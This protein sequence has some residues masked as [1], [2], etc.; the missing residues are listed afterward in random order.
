MSETETDPTPIPVAPSPEPRQ[1][2]AKVSRSTWFLVG[3]IL[4]LAVGL[5]GVLLYLRNQPQPERGI[6]P[7][8]EIMAMDPNSE[9]WG[10]NFPNQL[11][12]LKQTTLNNTPTTY[13]GSDPYSHLERDPR[14]VILFAGYPFSID[15]NEE[16][17]HLYALED[18]RATK[19]VNETTAGTCY[20]CKSSNN[21]E[22]WSKMGMAAYDKTLF[23]ELGKQITQPIGCA[24]CHEANTMRLVVTNPALEEG[25]KA[26]GLD[27][28][29]FTRQEMRTV[30]CGNCHVEYYFE[31]DGKYLTFPWAKGRKIE[32]IIEYYKEE[33]FKDWEHPQTKA[34]MIKAQHPE[35]EF[36]TA[37]STH[38]NAGVACAD[39]HMPY[40]RDGAAKFSSHNVHSPL[41]NPQAACGACHTDVD[42]VVERVK[43]IQDS[44]WEAMSAAEDALV[45]AINAIEK[46]SAIQ[47]ADAAKLDEARQL[48]REAHFMWD[49]MSAENSMGFHNPEEGL[50]ILARCVDLARQAQLLA[51]E[52]AGDVKILQG[53]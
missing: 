20:S 47:G 14:Q 21:P 41:F 19:R 43:I 5:I 16:R 25:L 38:Y 52:A 53:Q 3:L 49:F 46:A 22:L 17:G 26:Q 44:V 45:D 13:G 51:V 42:Y 34:P 2:R 10:I 4:I 6:Q 23:M 12:S 27:W 50:L 11:S 48:H 7:I 31:G 15:Y 30:V 37:G 35:F 1:P 40:V 18:V 24:N 9:N 33:G 28:R 29:N 36:Y 8:R 32:N 39:C